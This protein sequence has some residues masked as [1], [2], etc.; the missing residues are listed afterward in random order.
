MTRNQFCTAIK[1][2][3]YF[4]VTSKWCVCNIGLKSFGN[5]K[6]LSHSEYCCG[7]DS[8]ICCVLSFTNLQSCL[9]SVWQK[10]EEENREF[11][12]AYYLRL[13]VKH[14]IDEFN[15]LLEQQVHLMRQIHPTGVASMPTSN[16]SQISSCKAL[17]MSVVIVISMDCSRIILSV[18]VVQ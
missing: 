3:V 13:M 7:Q 15:R 6:A 5:L 10:L 14:Q 18:L 4:L 16:G 11:F 9:P 1:V 12:R 2:S 17:S 8:C